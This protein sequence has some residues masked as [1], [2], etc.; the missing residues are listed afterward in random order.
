[1]ALVPAISHATLIGSVHD[2]SSSGT[3]GAV[4]SQSGIATFQWGGTPSGSTN[5]A[6]YYQN[7]CQ[8]CHIPHGAQAYSATH[9]PLWNH[10]VATNAT[11][12]Y[13]TYDQAG[14]VS[15][16][17]LSLTPELGSSVACLSCHDGSIAVNQL[18][19]GING[20]GGVAT[21]VPSWA[22]KTDGGATG[23]HNGLTLMHPI[24]FSYTAA[25]AAAPGE[26]N[27]LP[28]NLNRML[29]GTDKTVECASCHDIHRTYGA[30][31]TVSHEL[32]VDL[33]GGAL[34]LTCHNK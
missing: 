23:A 16:N 3:A 33:N 34:C 26:L 1:M 17:S 27:N 24:G 18:Q 4:F 6:D 12:K 15:F 19:R 22:V 5:S 21:N 20:N 29:K 10:A 31:A 14:S 8:V 2:F 32:I 11:T 9:G 28:A 13:I 25:Q 30:S 7:P